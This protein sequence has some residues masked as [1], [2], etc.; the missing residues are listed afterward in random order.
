MRPL[1]NQALP[2]AA[3]LFDRIEA[4][5]AAADSRPQSRIEAGL[6]VLLDWVAVDPGRARALLLTEPDASSQTRDRQQDALDRGV[7]LLRRT[8]PADAT[9]PDCIEEVVVGAVASILRALLTTGEEGRAPELF[10]GIARFVLAS[11]GWDPVLA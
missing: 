6:L 11:F 9:R 7:E 3:P 2:L 4:A 5:C 1:G 10:D 8:V